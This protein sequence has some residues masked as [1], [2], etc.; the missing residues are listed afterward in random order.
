MYLGDSQRLNSLG[1]DS[2][3]EALTVDTVITVVFRLVNS[4]IVRF[5]I[6]IIVRVFLINA[7]CVYDTHYCV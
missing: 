1:E 4:Q 5:Y 6:H 3:V 2:V 7:G